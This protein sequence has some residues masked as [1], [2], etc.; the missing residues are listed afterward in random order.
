MQFVLYQVNGALSII[1][2]PLKSE[3]TIEDLNLTPSQEEIPTEIIIGG[4][5]IYSNLQKR[6]LSGKALMTKLKELNILRI[7]EVMFATI[8]SQGNFYADRY[9]DNID[10]KCDLSEDNTGVD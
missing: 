2:N 10:K 8:D 6:E 1:K 7:D 3:V 4:Q 9:I 5:I